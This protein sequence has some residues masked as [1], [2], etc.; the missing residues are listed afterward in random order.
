[1]EEKGKVLEINGNTVKVEV[2][3]AACGECDHYR[4]CNPTGEKKTIELRNDAGVKAGD[5]VTVAIDN[6]V[7]SRVA[8]LV[9][10]VPVLGLVA[11]Y[12][13]GERVFGSEPA[14]IA[15]G[16]V[17]FIMV[18]VVLAVLDRTVFSRKDR[19]NSRIVEVIGDPTPD[20]AP[21]S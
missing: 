13:I 20:N 6:A 21:E 19:L 12:L 4:I 2:E 3:S 17:T 16:T 15:A 8:V 7:F 5:R 9:Y 10:G 14:G 11:G 18:Y 1:M